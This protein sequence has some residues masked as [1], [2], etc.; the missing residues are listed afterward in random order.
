MDRDVGE[1]RIPNSCYER[2]FRAQT[3]SNACVAEAAVRVSEDYLA[4]KPRGTTAAFRDEA[5]WSSEFLRELPAGALRKEQLVLALAQYLA[6]DAVAAPPEA[7]E[8][9]AAVAP[10]AVSRAVRLSGLVRKPRSLKWKEVVGLAEA[11]PDELGEVVFVLKHFSSLVHRL[12]STEATERLGRLSGL[13][14]PEFVMHVGIDA[15]RRIARGEHRDLTDRRT[16]WTAVGNLIASRAATVD[17]RHTVPTNAEIRRSF[18]QL[19]MLVEGGRSRS[20]QADL[21][22]EFRDLVENRIVL[23]S[24]TG[25]WADAFSYNEPDIAVAKDGGKTHIEVGLGD[26]ELEAWSK[27]NDRLSA[28]RVYW[29]TR[30]SAEFIRRGPKRPR[31]AALRRNWFV[32]MRAIAAHLRLAEVY[33]V[34]DTTW[35]ATG[36]PVP[37]LN[38]LFALEI[39]METF[40][41]RLVS[42]YLRRSERHGNWSEALAWPAR[43][44]WVAGFSGLLPIAWTDRAALIRRIAEWT[45]DSGRGRR[46]RRK[47]EAIREAEAIVDFWSL[48][49]AELGRHFQRGD[50]GPAPTLLE[51]PFLRMGGK[52]AAFPW[53]AGIDYD[54]AEAALGNLRRVGWRREEVRNETRRI[55]ERLADLF[56]QCGFKVVAYWTPESAVEET[57]A[58]EVDLVC[59]RDGGVLVLEVKSTWMRQTVGEAWRHRRAARHAGLQLRRK[60][61]AVAAAITEDAGFAAALGSGTT[62]TPVR[63]WIVDTSLHHGHERFG[64]FLKVALEELVI[65]LRDDSRLLRDIDQG[66]LLDYAR[67]AR[68]SPDDKGTAVRPGL[69]PSGFSFSAFVDVVEGGRIWEDLA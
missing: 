64:G 59:A 5:F 40:E 34:D 45:V 35:D 33:G 11:H 7:L 2:A 14:L 3:R 57:V 21:L 17:A 49:C 38:A 62:S 69:Y 22:N 4:Q 23:E 65:A 46:D 47:A 26:R 16:H 66:F 20:G 31:A 61:A 28:L 12:L 56:K 25:T 19:S 29:L 68:S 41:N 48:D 63:G 9:F 39:V 37:V 6:Q 27:T 36:A 42:P 52:L 15:C 55:E 58:G 18:G 43:R 24:F 13:S 51:R 8:H 67:Q 44:E 54:A 60:T 53:M 1:S 50:P 10:E 30:A 32:Y